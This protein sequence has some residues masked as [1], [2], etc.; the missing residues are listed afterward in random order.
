[1]TLLVLAVAVFTSAPSAK[2]QLN[3]KTL[4]IMIEGIKSDLGSDTLGLVR[5]KF[6]PLLSKNDSKRTEWAFNY[7]A[8]K[9]FFFGQVQIIRP[10]ADTFSVRTVSDTSMWVRSLNA[11]KLL[12]RKM[13]K[14]T[15]MLWAYD[16]NMSSNQPYLVIGNFDGLS[17]NAQAAAA[18]KANTVAPAATTQNNSGAVTTTTTA[19][20]QPPP[21]QGPNTPQ[22]VTTPA[23]QAGVAPKKAPLPAA[24][25]TGFLTQDQQGNYYFVATDTNGAVL[26]IQPFLNPTPVAP[27]QTVPQTV[28]AQNTADAQ[29]AQ[30]AKDRENTKLWFKEEPSLI[31]GKVNRFKWNAVTESWDLMETADSDQTV[32]EDH[33]EVVNPGRHGVI[34]NH[35]ADGR[36][37][38]LKN[39]EKED[40]MMI[41]R[42]YNLPDE[43]PT[44][45]SSTAVLARTGV[46]VGD[47]GGYYNSAGVWVSAGVSV[48]AGCTG[49]NYYGG[50]RRPYQ[51]YLAEQNMRRA[52]SRGPVGGPYWRRFYRQ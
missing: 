13:A 6:A 48:G 32:H 20:V 39:S 47:A 1:M 38:M 22:S 46:F 35:T 51:Q 25:Q 31:P 8:V 41:R 50:G 37:E 7:S 23:P 3:K 34:I 43:T 5:E 49:G 36:A 29:A 52:Q 12:N 30:L 14:D 9:H 11:S 17:Q 19:S 18:K 44:S 2:A 16:P 27:T 26:G 4:S 21:V 28:T 10:V 33:V 15:L 45:G 40:A 42:L 24:G